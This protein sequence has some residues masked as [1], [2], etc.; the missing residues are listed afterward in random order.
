[1]AWDTLKCVT[2]GLKCGAVVAE[3]VVE[4]GTKIKCNGKCLIKKGKK[5]C[6]DCIKCVTGDGQDEDAPKLETTSPP[7]E[8]QEILFTVPEGIKD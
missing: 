3:C 4:C 1:M 6:K 8:P 2:C 7:R 5:G